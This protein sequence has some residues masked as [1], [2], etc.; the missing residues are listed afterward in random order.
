MDGRRRKRQRQRQ[1]QQPGPSPPTE[2]TTL[3]RREIAVE[4]RPLKTTC[5]TSVPTS[6]ALCE[7]HVWQDLMD[8]LL[9]QIITF[10]SSFQDLVAFS[11]TCYSWRTAL[12]SFPSTYTF[13]FPP[14]HLK[15]DI[16]DIHTYSR[17][18][19]YSLLSCRKWKLG[20][21]SK[22]NISLCC[23]APQN[24]P[25][26]M[27]YLGCSYGYLIFSY[28]KNCL[29]V[30]VYNG[31]KMKPPILQFLSNKDIYYGI[32]TA[33]LNSP[34][35]HLLLCSKSSIFFW[36]VGTNSWS[37]HPFCGDR[38]LQIVL[39][40]GEMFAMDFHHRLHTVRFAPQ[41]SMQELG[42]LWAEEML[43]G[44]HFKP[45]L[46]ICGDMLLMLDLSVGT[47][48]LHG[49][50]GTFQVFRLD[51]SAETAKWMKMAKMENQ[52]LF[53]SFD[54]RNPTFSCM[55]PERWGGKSNY[56]YVAKP[57]DDSD[58]PWTAVELG[59]PV[60]STTDFVPNHHT[61]LR[62]EPNGHCN[63]L[64]HLWVLRSSTY[65]VGQ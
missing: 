27:R 6:P 39:F 29:L 64:E 3:G 51:F 62:R 57:S 1:Q 5:H 60:P 65:G 7:P 25:N 9:H 48:Q 18:F 31:T 44:V 46:V 17:N 38:I 58:E 63:Q 53:V 14:L 54:R 21:P 23:S 28:R 59:Q 15:P 56:I 45:W 42:V 19:K 61:I 36:Q 4:E 32:L 10:L 16:P 47:H 26:R 8:S 41:F 34:N 49:F 20:D 50:A 13:T 2:L 22:R 40:K 35:S 52:A 43:V 55:R 12:S 37:E 33:P 11:G 30:D 24:T